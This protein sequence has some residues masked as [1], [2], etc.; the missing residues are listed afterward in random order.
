MTCKQAWKQAF[1]TVHRVTFRALYA[2]CKRASKLLFVSKLALLLWPHSR[3]WMIWLPVHYNSYLVCDFIKLEPSSGNIFICLF[4][5]TTSVMT[6]SIYMWVS[7]LL[8]FDFLGKPQPDLQ[9]STNLIAQKD[10]EEVPTHSVKIGSWE[11]GEEPL[12]IEKQGEL[13]CS[14]LHLEQ[15][16]I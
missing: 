5:E 8:A 12:V 7:Y 3:K 16:C 14:P 15:L 1:P 2:L 9:I 11:N 10:L 6:L 13:C 4:K